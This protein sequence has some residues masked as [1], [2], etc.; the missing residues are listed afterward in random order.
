MALNLFV[1]QSVFLCILN[2]I[3]IG[4]F[5]VAI[6]YAD[7]GYTFPMCCGGGDG[8]NKRKTS[9]AGAGGG[10]GGGGGGAKYTTK[11]SSSAVGG[12][13]SFQRVPY[14]M[15]RMGLVFC[16]TLLV[17]GVDGGGGLD[18]YPI[19]LVMVLNHLVP[20][21]ALCTGSV[22]TVQ[23]AY[24]IFPMFDGKT[25]PR[26][27]PI[28]LYTIPFVYAGLEV[29]AVSM[30]FASDHETTGPVIAL[31]L[32][33]PILTWM[34]LAHMVGVYLMLRRHLT[35]FMAAVERGAAARG[36]LTSSAQPPPPADVK[37][38]RIVMVVEPVSVAPS[39]VAASANA[40]VTSPKA[41]AETEP[42]AV[43]VPVPVPPPKRMGLALPGPAPRL[44]VSGGG[45]GGGGGGWTLNTPSNA[46]ATVPAPISPRPPPSVTGAGGGGGGGTVSSSPAP[47]PAASP[48]AGRFDHIHAALNRLFLQCLV[49]IGCGALASQVLIS[50][51]LNRLTH[52][53]SIE[54][55][56]MV[57]GSGASYVPTIHSLPLSFSVLLAWIP[58]VTA[59]P[60]SL[61]SCFNL[62]NC[63]CACSS[64]ASSAPSSKDRVVP[65][66]RPAENGGG[67]EVR[68]NSQR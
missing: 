66:T 53:E 62:C 57:R 27:V 45:G 25:V 18:V 56:L 6:L 44:D 50:Q 3:Y 49:S 35:K 19:P 41:E 38:N 20:A 59:M 47:K 5:I 34:V 24:T 15:R 23:T 37:S 14:Y 12:G 40:G 32:V 65:L 67:M 26:A 42:S 54:E 2:T 29:V 22:W 11:A 30:Y 63:K 58:V 48:G 31:H 9:A 10:G 39:A 64:D 28:V 51:F 13:A 46:G 4:F 16:I 21:V 7:Y 60:W 33:F 17:W 36:T 43:P 68:I 1:A 8:N 52:P 55:D 61:A